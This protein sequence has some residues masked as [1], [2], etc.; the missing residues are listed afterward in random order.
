MKQFL[1]ARNID[2]FCKKGTFFFSFSFI[3]NIL[4]YPS[5]LFRNSYTM[6]FLRDKN[7]QL[8]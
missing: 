6:F 4:N 1:T 2:F 5:C 8:S 3:C 7:K